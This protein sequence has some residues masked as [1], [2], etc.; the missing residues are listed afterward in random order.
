MRFVARAQPFGIPFPIL[1]LAAT[2][3]AGAVLLRFALLGRYSYA[4][5]GNEQAARLSGV[6]VERCKMAAYTL[7]GMLAGVSSLIVAGR[8]AWMQPQE[9][10]GFELDVIAAVVIGGTSLYGGEG[11]MLG[12]LI[13]AL[14][15]GVVRNGL[16]LMAVEYNIQKIIIGAIIIFAV[17][18][19]VLARRLVRRG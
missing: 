12:T 17:S 15:M 19:D 9:G 7:C 2:Y 3:L 16:N 5:G 1:L 18:V 10:D 11:T 14:I 4:I 6:R 13:G 8:L